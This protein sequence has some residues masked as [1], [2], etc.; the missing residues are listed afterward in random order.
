M[1]LLAE[2]QLVGLGQG[3]A[4]FR[5]LYDDKGKRVSVRTSRTFDL[6]A[7]RKPGKRYPT[8]AVLF[9]KHKI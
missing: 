8:E 1:K 4:V 2:N 5:N 3:V 6:D 9:A 7:E